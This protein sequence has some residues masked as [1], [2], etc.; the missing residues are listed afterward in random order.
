MLF[1]VPPDLTHNITSFILKKSVLQEFVLEVLGLANSRC[2][3]CFAWNGSQREGI[4]KHITERVE[5]APIMSL[6]P[7]APVLQR[8]QLRGSNGSC[9]RLSTRLFG[10]VGFCQL[11]AGVNCALGHWLFG[12]GA[13]ALLEPDLQRACAHGGEPEHVL[14]R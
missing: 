6:K 5:C 2:N 10:S 1:P 7:Y 8:R 12:S 3:H 9:R 11:D 4:W 13:N 14:R